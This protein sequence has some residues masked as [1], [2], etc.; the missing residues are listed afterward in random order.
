MIPTLIQQQL[1]ESLWKIAENFTI[2]EAFL[3][4]SPDIIQLVLESKSLAEQNEKQN[5][6][7]LLPIMSSEQI[8]KLRDILTREKKKLAE[9]NA[10]YAKK[11]AEINQQY[12]QAIN[13]TAYYEA[14]AKLQA[15]ESK[16]REEDLIAADN[17]LAQM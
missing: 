10:K 2:P 17:L 16:K 6:F 11:E 4:D 1:P 13:P 9:I 8:D 7:N 15:A 12:K 3:K 14:Q 5:W